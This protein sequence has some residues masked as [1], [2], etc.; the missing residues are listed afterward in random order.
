MVQRFS[1]RV[2][3]E[4]KERGRWLIWGRRGRG[5]L[6]N[7]CVNSECGGC[8]SWEGSELV[9]ERRIDLCGTE[10][11]WSRDVACTRGFEFAY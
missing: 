8:R 3:R 5:L 11:K 9:G 4:M 6:S 2:E 1:E 7:V 10:S